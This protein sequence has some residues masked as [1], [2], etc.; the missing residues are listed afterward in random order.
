MCRLSSCYRFSGVKVH[1]SDIFQEG[2]AGNTNCRHERTS[3]FI[4]DIYITYTLNIHTDRPSHR[5]SVE[6]PMLFQSKKSPVQPCITTFIT[7]SHSAI[8]LCRNVRTILH[9]CATSRLPSAYDR[10]T[11]AR[12][13]TCLSGFLLADLSCTDC[14]TGK[15]TKMTSANTEYL[16]AWLTLHVHRLPLCNT[17]SNTYL[18]LSFHAATGFIQFIWLGVYLA[19]H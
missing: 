17:V 11:D 5:M 12:K 4:S 19:E 8:S 3:M 7:L 6:A 14:H 18:V 9:C 1:S 13:C 16:L 2:R 15:R 10:H